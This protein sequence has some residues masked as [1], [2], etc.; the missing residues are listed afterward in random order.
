MAEHG[1]LPR[2]TLGRSLLR[3]ESGDLFSAVF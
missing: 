1:K 2:E 3:R